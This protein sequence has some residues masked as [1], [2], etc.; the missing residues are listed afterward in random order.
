MNKKNKENAEKPQRNYIIFHPGK[1]HKEQNTPYI[2]I[3][4]FVSGF[5]E[6]NIEIRKMGKS[7]YKNK[8]QSMYFIACRYLWIKHCSFLKK[9]IFLFSIKCKRKKKS[10]S[11]FIY[12]FLEMEK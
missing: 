1:A 11:F 5:K 6:K 4:F 7:S 10:T 12:G 2:K 8:L 3:L 9:K